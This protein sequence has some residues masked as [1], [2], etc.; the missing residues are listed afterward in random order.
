MNHTFKIVFTIDKECVAK[1]IQTFADIAFDQARCT[2][3]DWCDRNNADGNVTKTIIGNTVNI[4]VEVTAA[5]T[6]HD[7]QPILKRMSNL[8]QYSIYCHEVGASSPK[9]FMM[10]GKASVAVFQDGVVH[11]HVFEVQ[12]VAMGG[13]GFY[14]LLKCSVCRKLVQRKVQVD[15]TVDAD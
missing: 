8:S 11:N 1:E 14:E 13:D 3:R 15:N 5:C 12:Q 4:G 9:Y 7:L 10:E 6:Y 2:L